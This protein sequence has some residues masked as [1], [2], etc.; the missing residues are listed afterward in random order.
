M[1]AQRYKPIMNTTNKILFSLICIFGATCSVFAQSKSA[2][3]EKSI[4][5]FNDVLRQLDVSYVDT[6]PYEKMTETAI[7]QMLRQVDPYTVYYPKDK[8]RELRMMTT[9][10]YGGVGAIIQQREERSDS[11][12]ANKKDKKKAGKYIII[13]EPYEGKPAQKAGLRAGDRIL[14]ID[15]KKMTNKTVSEVSDA[16]RGIPHTKLAVKVQRYGEPEPLEVVIEREEIKLP[17]VSY[18]GM[19]NDKIAYIAFNEFT[20][21]SADEVRKALDDLVQNH[22]AK[23]LVFDLRDN[24]GGIIDEAVKIV[25]LFVGKGQ[26]V[27]STRGRIKQSQRTYSTTQDAAYPTLPIVI[28]VNHN[29]ASA[30]EIVAGSMQDLKRATLVGERTFGKGLVQSVRAVA[31]DGYIKLTTAKYYLPSG[32]CIQAIDYSK[33]QGKAEKDTTGGILPDIVIAD[34]TRKVDIS[35]TLYSKQLFFDYATRY[36][37]KHETITPVNEFALTDED[38]EDFCVFLDEEGFTYE[39]ETG[40]YFND[41]LEMAQHEDLDS[42]TIAGLKAFEPQLR[43]SFREAISRHKADVLELLEAEIIER[44]YYQQGRSEYMIKHDK[45]LQRAIEVLQ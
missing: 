5:V 24:G 22:G 41:M 10:K 7:N 3:A 29:S 1:P 6:L 13:S 14:E 34:S 16:L 20:E 8:D 2:R 30:S 25:N 45:D 17:P 32:R 19:L 4:V 43:P 11:T 33:H 37:A 40:K 27:V 44:Y 12:K 39:T 26:T 35:Y 28:M 21:H 38:I 9:G 36:R 15:G 42:A 23:A 18:Y 31:Y